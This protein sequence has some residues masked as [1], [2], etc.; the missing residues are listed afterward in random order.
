MCQLLTYS[1]QC[2]CILS[3]MLSSATGCTEFHCACPGDAQVR[4]LCQSQV[5]APERHF[6][7]NP[8]TAFCDQRPQAWCSPSTPH[9]SCI[10]VAKPAPHYSRSVQTTVCRC[11]TALPGTQITPLAF[12]CHAAFHSECQI[13]RFC[14]A[15]VGRYE[16]HA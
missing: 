9:P 4:I 10:A 12:L 6:T 11:T 13:L 15:T 7:L 14:K 1:L 3:T 5:C 8:G 2:C 16:E